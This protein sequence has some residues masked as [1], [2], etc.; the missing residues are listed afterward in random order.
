MRGSLNVLYTRIYFD[1]EQNNNDP[2]LLTME[3][4]RR[5]TLIA[6]KE[7]NE[8]KTF[9]HFDIHMQGAKETVFLDI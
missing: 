7:V 6:T 2:L 1:D 9:Y 4:E 8:G 5:S 3:P